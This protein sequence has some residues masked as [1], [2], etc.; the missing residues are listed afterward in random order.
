V[1]MN[2]ARRRIYIANQGSAS[3][4]V[5]RDSALQGVTEAN[6]PPAL[7]VPLDA[8]IVRGMLEIGS[9]LT[10]YGSR[11]EVFDINGRRVLDIPHSALRIRHSVDVSRLAPGVY[12]VQEGPQASSFKPQALWK[13][14]LTQ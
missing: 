4:S 14:I 12:F 5:L 8:T 6:R 3:V 2:P 10:A 9:Q 7:R 13:V 1:A 11:L